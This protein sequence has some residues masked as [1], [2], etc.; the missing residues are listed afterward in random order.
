MGNTPVTL[1]TPPIE[2]RQSD[3]RRACYGGTLRIAAFLP[4]VECRLRD[5]SLTGVR[6]VIAE[7]VV[8]PRVV[9]LTVACRN[10]TRRAEIVWRSGTQAGLAFLEGP[11]REVAT[12]AD[13]RAAWNAAAPPDRLH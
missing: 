9:D 7:D 10:Q 2:R 3:R 13:A 4:E 1:T 12:E 11:P 5:H 8:L 6:I